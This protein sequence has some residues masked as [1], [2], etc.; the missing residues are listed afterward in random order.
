[1]TQNLNKKEGVVTIGADGNYS[2]TDKIFVSV[3]FK[4]LFDRLDQGFQNL[5]LEDQPSND[6]HLVIQYM[7]KQ[8]QTHIWNDISA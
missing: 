1:M 4:T 3:L 2:D 7:Y 8:K 5:K 6:L